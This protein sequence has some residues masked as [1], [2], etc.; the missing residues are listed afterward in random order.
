MVQTVRIIKKEKPDVIHCHS[1]KGGMIGRIVGFV[2]NTPV[3]Y[4]PHAF[5]F[6]FAESKK[7]SW[8]FLLLEKIARLNSRMLAC[9]ES[10]HEL[11]IKVVG[12]KQERT[13]VWN[14][15]IPAI[16][17]QDVK[18]PDGILPNERFIIS[19]GRS[20]YPKNPLLMVETMKRVYEKHSDIHFYL[21]GVG[22]YSPQWLNVWEARWVSVPRE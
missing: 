2:T 17:F 6:L 16:L 18:Q 4:T 9:S 11:G 1:A 5:S 8:G 21:V 19:I 14:N 15:A 3:F 22:F 10:E 7:K 20:S 13:F 12:Y